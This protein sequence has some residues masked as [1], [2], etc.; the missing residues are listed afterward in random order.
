M[1]NIVKLAVMFLVTSI[2]A[3]AQVDPDDLQAIRTWVGDPN[4]MVTYLGQDTDPDLL[5]TEYGMLM[6]SNRTY[7]HEDGSDLTTFQVSISSHQVITYIYNSR[8][9]VMLSINDLNYRQQAWTYIQNHLPAVKTATLQQTDY[10]LVFSPVYPNGVIDWV[11]RVEIQLYDDGTP[12]ALHVNDGVAPVYTGTIPITLNQAQVLCSNYLGNLYPGATVSYPQY[13]YTNQLIMA[14]DTL[15]VWQ[16]VWRRFSEVTSDEDQMGF[17]VYVNAVDGSVFDDREHWLGGIID[18]KPKYGKQIG[19]RI[20]RDGQIIRTGKHT[21]VPIGWLQALA[22][23][24]KL[25]AKVGEKAFT[26]DGKRVA[27]PAK[28]TAKAGTLYLPWQALKSLPGIKCSYD[29]KLNK[30]E[31]T[32]AK[33]TEKPAA[34]TTPKPVK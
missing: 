3:H 22:K 19:F 9:K 2:A 27:L 23:S 31:I 29:A 24:H 6:P 8:N 14:P 34:K 32:T 18:S 1:N 11:N 33:V 30:L 17:Y 4:Y 15:G 10:P 16:P 28:V 12:R 5:T 26:L 25:T 20:L 21:D 13:F 7:L